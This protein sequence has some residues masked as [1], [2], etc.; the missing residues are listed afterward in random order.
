MF[1]AAID[2]AGEAVRLQLGRDFAADHRH[3]RALVGAQHLQPADDGVAR[4]LVQM[5]KG[6]FLKLGADPLA[7]DRARQGG[8][9]VE[10]FASDALALFLAGNEFQGAHIVQAVGQLDH[11]HPH[12]AGD[13]QDE[14]AQVFGLA[15]VLGGQLQPRQLG[16]TLH[17]LADLGAEQLVDVGAGDRGVLDHIVQQGG[18][19]GGGVQ[20][21]VGQYARHLDRMGEVGVA[22]RA[23]LRAVHAH[24]VDI[25]AI[26]QRL[27]R[28][29]VVALDLLDQLILAQ[30]FG[31]GLGRLRLCRLSGRR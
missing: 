14:L 4:H 20:P 26:E 3:R 5:G 15:G 22:G 16:H 13:G 29:G 1:F 12:V 19:D 9:D 8:V 17:Q 24:G 25:G 10:G 18:D 23:S 31:P 21:I 11:Q 7:A 28:R 27:V 30:Q 2:P 6:Q